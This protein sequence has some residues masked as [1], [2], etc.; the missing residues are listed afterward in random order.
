M[1]RFFKR[2]RRRQIH[3]EPFPQ[4]WLGILQSHV[5]IYE[6]LPQEAQSRLQDHIQVFLHEKTFEGCGG[7]TIT[8]EIR[9]TIA[10][11]ACI[12]L[13][14]KDISHF[15]SLSTI[16]VYPSTFRSKAREMLPGGIVVERE[17]ARLG[18]SWTRGNV[19]LAWDAVRRGCVNL[20]DGAN[21]VYHEFAH[22][23]DQEDGAADG[24][25]I[26]ATYAMYG[27][28]AQTLGPAFAALQA[29]TS[30]GR[31]TL[32]DSYG[33]KS[34]AEFFAVLT[35]TFFEQPRALRQKHPRVYEQLKT[36]YGLDPATW[37]KGATPGE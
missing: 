10:A 35:E 31:R 15:D 1:F 25:P 28:W 29:A 30:K 24:A 5:P 4:Q 34:P 22:Q 13:L 27:P 3:Q 36:F 26:L 17:A 12:L 19:V 20:S 37:T 11:H 8:D 6:R 2:L 9:V 33:A 23:L 32:I 14:N 7:L 18:E 16:L 21:V